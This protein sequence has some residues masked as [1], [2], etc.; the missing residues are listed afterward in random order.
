MAYIRSKGYKVKQNLL[1]QVIHEI[2]PFGPN[3]RIRRKK[4]LKRR[5]YKGW[6]GSGFNRVCHIDG[7]HKVSIMLVLIQ[8]QF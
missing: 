8:V 7:W 1:R 6:G 2:D 5:A 3:Y 4:K